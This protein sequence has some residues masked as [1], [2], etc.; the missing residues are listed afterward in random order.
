MKE[1]EAQVLVAEEQRI[2]KILEK[3]KRRGGLGSM[4]RARGEPYRTCN[5]K[6]EDLVI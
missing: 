6:L 3:E 1:R 5:L 2:V 4:N